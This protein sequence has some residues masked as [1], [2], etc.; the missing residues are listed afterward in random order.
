[1][2]LDWP[3]RDWKLPAPQ[4]VQEVALSLS[5]KDPA[6]QDEHERLWKA[7]EYSPCGHGRH[8]EL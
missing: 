3:A 6:G 7:D 4:L 1:M 2:Q 5:L 8:A